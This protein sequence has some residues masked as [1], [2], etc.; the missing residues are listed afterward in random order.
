[1]TDTQP[2]QHYLQLR[3]EFMGYL[4]AITRDAELSE[5]VYQNAAVV[6]IEKA[7]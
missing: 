1:M 3:S 4:Y 2:I 6:V 7:E 5:E